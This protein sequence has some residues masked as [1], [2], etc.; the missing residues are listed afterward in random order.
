[1]WES[2]VRAVDPCNTHTWFVTKIR[3]VHKDANKIV[4]S[5]TVLGVAVLYRVAI[6]CV[7]YRSI[8]NCEF[9]LAFN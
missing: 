9:T 4:F 7:S 5:C 6:P 2:Q 8:Y 3:N 1:M